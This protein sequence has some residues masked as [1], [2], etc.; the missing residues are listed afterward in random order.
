MIP[1]H[2][3]QKLW[4]LEVKVLI[5][6]HP[7]LLLLS[8]TCTVY[9][10]ADDN[11]LSYS[12]T[13]PDIIKLRLEEASNIAIKWFDEN[14]MKANPSKFQAI[15]FSKNDLSLNLTIAN[16]AIKTEPTVKLLGV[17]LDNKL[18]LSGTSKQCIELAKTWIMTVK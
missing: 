9:N 8:N 10:Y 12:H 3:V 11:T 14:Y 15:C 1:E 13:D 17:E 7:P 16:N 5:L 4:L 18:S 2:L 6:P